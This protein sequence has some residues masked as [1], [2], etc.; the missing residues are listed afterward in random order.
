M[1]KEKKDKFDNICF[2]CFR[3]LDECICDDETENWE[4][5]ETSW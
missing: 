4:E 5:V 3:D 1:P 2:D